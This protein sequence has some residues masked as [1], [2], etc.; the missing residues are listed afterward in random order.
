MDCG[1]VFVFVQLTNIIYAKMYSINTMGCKS[2]LSRK[3]YQ[4][5]AECT[6]VCCNILVHT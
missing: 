5:I 2:K 1:S 6:I 4:N 3:R